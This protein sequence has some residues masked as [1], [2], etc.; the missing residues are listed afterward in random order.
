MLAR[1]QS[2]E[3]T[4]NKC[5]QLQCMRSKAK[6]TKEQN[7]SKQAKKQNKQRKRK[8]DKQ[9]NERKEKENRKKV[10][11]LHNTLSL[12]TP[13]LSRITLQP[14]K[15]RNKKQTT[16]QNKQSKTFLQRVQGLN[17]F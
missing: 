12:P 11:R 2:K 14:N 8:R 16:K 13:P 4:N 6:K 1:R 5:I 9:R 7:K 15:T 10:M 17:V 3:Q